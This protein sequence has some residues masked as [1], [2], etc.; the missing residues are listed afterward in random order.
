[1]TP[2]QK[3]LNIEEL[4][5]FFNWQNFA[6]KRNSQIHK[7]SNIRGFQSPKSEEN[8]FSKKTPDFLHLGA[9][10]SQILYKR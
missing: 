4:D 8:S 7:L 9:V 1:L 10:C 5:C 3:K 6:K 2:R